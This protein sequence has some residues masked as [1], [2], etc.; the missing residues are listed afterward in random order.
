MGRSYVVKGETPKR[1]WESSQ[2]DVVYIEGTRTKL[3][4][5]YQDRDTGKTMFPLRPSIRGTVAMGANNIKMI[6]RVEEGRGM[7]SIGTPAE[8]RPGRQGNP[9][10]A[11]YQWRP[12]KSG[13][14]WYTRLFKGGKRHPSVSQIE[15]IPLVSRAAAVRAAEQANY[16]REG[17]PRRV[18]NPEPVTP[19]IF[20]KFPESEGGEVIAL[21]P[22][23]KEG[24]YGQMGSYMH[25][26]QHGAASHMLVYRTKPAKPAEYAS[27]KAELEGIGYRLKV[28]QKVPSYKAMSH[29]A[30][31]SREGNPGPAAIPAR[32]TPATVS[33]KGGQIQIRMGG[34]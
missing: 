5:P 34:R 10:A 23:D 17:M 6:A 13:G 11:D 33:R 16:H 8:Y 32:W 29:A 3:G 19:V 18:V 28:L 22:Y 7:Q 27:L 20:R 9:A 15:S 14:Y 12:V 21:F 24:D 26:G 31:R 2:G 1:Y 30:A 25:T 4:R